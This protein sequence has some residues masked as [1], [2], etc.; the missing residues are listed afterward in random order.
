MRDTP[1]GRVEPVGGVSLRHSLEELVTYGVYYLQY[2]YI[3]ILKPT[4][5]NVYLYELFIWSLFSE[6]R[7]PT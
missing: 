1:L 7:C 4:A 2:R 6:T 3:T 5:R